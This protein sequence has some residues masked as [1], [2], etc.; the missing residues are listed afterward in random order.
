MKLK[1][2]FFAAACA[3]ALSASAASFT[4]GKQTWPPKADDYQGGTSGVLFDLLFPQSSSQ[5]IY[6]ASQLTEL[7]HEVNADGS[8]TVSLI[9]DVQMPFYMGSAYYLDGEATFTVYL[10]P[11]SLTSFPVDGAE[12]QWIDYEAEGTV[13]GT[14]TITSTDDDV[15]EAAYGEDMVMVNV[16]FDTPYEYSGGGFVLTVK[17]ENSMADADY[18]YWFMGT[19]SYVASTHCSAIQKDGVEMSGRIASTSNVL[20]VVNF[21]Y[22][23]KEIPAPSNEE[24]GDPAVYSVGDYD[25]CAPSGAT[26]PDGYLPVNAD[27]Y[28]YS[29][30]QVIYTSGDLVGLN[31]VA[32]DKVSY[33]D[34]T[35]LTFK[36]GNSMYGYYNGSFSGKVY[37]QNYDGVTFPIL[38]NKQ[39]WI[40][41][42]PEVE[43]SFESD[44]YA[45]D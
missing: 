24:V 45:Y 17:C 18:D 7:P 38:N 32:G 37:I 14:A 27:Y 31:K 16:H 21:V 2:T 15:L 20:P 11:C 39:Q 10:T 33:A 9:T 42:D 1:T 34:I 41:F 8:S 40:E 29:F 3:L 19:Y 25:K 22:E 23:T 28:N 43:A 6:S 44:T 13:S 4:P 5:N 12:Y 36:L 35:D 30:A 26:T